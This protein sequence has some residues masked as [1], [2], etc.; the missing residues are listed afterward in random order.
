[1]VFFSAGEVGEDIRKLIL[2]IYNVFLSKDG[3]VRIQFQ[4]FKDS[5][6]FKKSYVKLR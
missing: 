5:E 6:C 1:M 2:K 3:R 4:N